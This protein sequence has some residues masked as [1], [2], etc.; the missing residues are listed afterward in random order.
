MRTVD[1]VVQP[2]VAPRTS[3]AEDRHFLQVVGRPS[4]TRLGVLRVYT[5]AGEIPREWRAIDAVASSVFADPP[6]FVLGLGQTRAI[7]DIVYKG[8]PA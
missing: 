4:R 3:L 6:N 5:L 7:A 8:M 2:G 1:F